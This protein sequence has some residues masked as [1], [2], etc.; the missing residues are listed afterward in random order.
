MDNETHRQRVA[1]LH[2]RSFDLACA[3][4]KAY[5]KRPFLDEP[6]RVVWRELV[7]AVTSSTFNF[8]EADAASSDSDFL[9]KMRIALR[10]VKEARVAMR[11]IVACQ[12]AGYA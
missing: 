5:P 7:K 1:A 4:L 11:L 12:L 3:V 6:S 2:R 9:A 10:E 8:E